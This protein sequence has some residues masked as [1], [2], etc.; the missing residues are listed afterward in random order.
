VSDRRITLAAPVLA[1]LPS[2]A[3]LTATIIDQPG[4]GPVKGAALPEPRNRWATTDVADTLPQPGTVFDPRSRAT[5]LYVRQL[6]AGYGLER[7]H[8][9][10]L[11]PQLEVVGVSLVSEG[12]IDLVHCRF[13]NL[14]ARAIAH[15]A[16]SFVLVHN[17]P[18]GNPQPSTQDVDVTRRLKFISGELQIRLIDHLIV[19]G[20]RIYSFA[21]GREL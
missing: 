2:E 9:I 8:A 6:S 10:F 1:N 16:S 15:D 12:S 3:T 18:S 7:L 4:I 11:G 17:H 20:D 5:Q 14:F 19:A 21:A 13:R